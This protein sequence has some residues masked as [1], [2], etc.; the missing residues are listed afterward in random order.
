M[1]RFIPGDMV[2][3]TNPVSRFHGRLGMV[4]TLVGPD[5]PNPALTI[6]LSPDDGGPTRPGHADELE[7]Y[8]ALPKEEG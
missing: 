7:L 4:A 3:V 2:R 6:R 8:S 5:A 1:S